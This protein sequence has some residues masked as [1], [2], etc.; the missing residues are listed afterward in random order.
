VDPAAIRSHGYFHAGGDAVRHLFRVIGSLDSL[1]LGEK[2]IAGQVKEAY[3]RAARNGGTDF[4]LNHLF[5]SGIHAGKRIHAETGVHE[6]AVSISHA[7]VELARKVL[8]DLSG[9][10]VGVVG[11]GEM[12]ELAAQHLH[13]AGVR[14]FLFFNRSV[15]TAERLAAAFGGGVHRLS[16]LAGRLADCDIVVSATGAPDIVLTAEQV[17]EGA[18][19]RGGKP[20][21]LIDIAAPRDIDPAAGSVDGVFLFTIDDLKSATNENA[22][23]RR[24]AARKAQAIVEEEAEKIEAWSQSLEIVPTLRTLREK[25]QALADREIEKWSLGQPAETRRQLEALGRGLMN[26]FL[27][28]PTT[29]L[30]LLGEQGDARR[31]SYYA[32]MLFHLD[33][34]PG[35]SHGRE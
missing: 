2:Q 1:I 3:Q 19:Q 21:F 5:Q 22:D 32:G 10:T 27:H 9:R 28:D 7:A 8:G 20:L 26:K 15:E 35:A 6:G 31:A 29:R 13:Q 17:R 25:Y 24:L 33:G 23:L 34:E 18:E 11:A 4:F 30:K 12:G 16:D 14:H